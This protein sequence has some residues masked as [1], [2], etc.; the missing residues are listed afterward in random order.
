MS[1]AFLLLLTSIIITSLWGKT[2]FSNSLNLEYQDT[3]SVEIVVD[4]E[5]LKTRYYLKEKNVILDSVT[6]EDAYGKPILS[7]TEDSTITIRSASRSGVGMRRFNTTVY[8]IKDKKFHELLTYCSFQE[9]S[10]SLFSMDYFLDS[11]WHKSLDSA[12]KINCLKVELGDTTFYEKELM[13]Q[14]R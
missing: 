2:K 14:S 11:C 9:F 8:E 5:N 3:I 12:F 6:L 13:T 4:Y 7:Y 1:I 10:D